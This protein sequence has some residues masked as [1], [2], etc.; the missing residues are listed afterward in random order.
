MTEKQMKFDRVFK[1]QGG[2]LPIDQL[3]PEIID[4]Y[5]P[6]REIFATCLQRAQNRYPN[7]PRLNIDIIRSFAINALAKKHDGEF[8]IGINA[9]AV[10]FLS[11]TFAK[12]FSHR[13]TA[14]TIGSLEATSEE[15]IE[16]NVESNYGVLSYTKR[17]NR[18]PKDPDR[19]GY[20]VYFRNLAIAFLTYHEIGHVANGHLGYLESLGAHEFSE[21][22]SIDT[23]SRRDPKTLQTLEMDADSFAINSLYREF[24]SN[25][26][27]FDN[28]DHQLLHLSSY[29]IML[30]NFIFS[31][32]IFFRLFGVLDLDTAD[33][34]L[35]S[36]PPA[37]SRMTMMVANIHTLFLAN[38][39]LNVD[40]KK[41]SKAVFDA[42]H[43]A[44]QAF[45]NCFYQNFE[46]GLIIK[47]FEKG[48]PYN[49]NISKNWKDV[50]PLVKPY[51]YADL[52]K[53]I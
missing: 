40:L 13:R 23:E 12:I 17:S 1:I 41:I 25:K 52:P 18:I 11:D 35:S 50:Y 39:S 34:S 26:R 31:I 36:H 10:E 4:A 6:I 8:Y 30:F 20:A 32:H 21:L 51:A 38:G 37:S 9:G 22:P 53:Q 2:I 27:A 7:I 16:L 3:S 5:V 19:R 14:P 33:E 28:A 46:F 15:K 47:N 42:I 43:Q 48:M 24:V 49:S 45:S 44:E 29:E